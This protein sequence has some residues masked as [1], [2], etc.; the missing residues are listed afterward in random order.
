M[1]FT[2]TFHPV[3]RVATGLA[4][5]A[6]AAVGVRLVVTVRDM[7]QLSQERRQQS[8]TD[9]LTGLHNRRYLFHVLDTFFE[10]C[11]ATGAERSA[12]FLFVDLNRFKEINDTF[13]HP[14]GDELLRQ[15][16]TRLTGALRDTD[17]LVR[18]GG[19]EFAVVL[20][21]GDASYAVDVAQRLTDSLEEPFA[22]DVVSA[23]I[24]ASIGI[25][26]AP[27]DAQ[28]SAGLVWCADVA[29]YR[30]KLGGTAFAS[31]TQDLDE[32]GDQM[33]LVEDLR[34]A[35]NGG[36]LTLHYQPQLNLTTGEILNVEA[37]VRW[38][39]PKLGLLPPDRFIPLAEESGLIAPLTTWVID[40][41]VEQV[42]I[43]RD[44]ARP[45]TVSV[46]I[47][48]S[49]LL[50]PG[51]VDQVR[52]ALS[53]RNLGTDALVLEI[54]ETC[55]ISDFERAR[56]VIGELQDHGF[57]VSIDDFGAGV[58]SLAY[59]GNLAVR[60]LKLDRVFILGTEGG[61]DIRQVD[62]I[63][64]T[65][66]L[67]HAMGLRIV[68]EGIEDHET[69]RLLADLGCDYAQGYWIS[70]P[71]PADDLAFQPVQRIAAR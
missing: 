47:S 62:L 37:L 10:D 12:A 55:V 56:A 64:S 39:H 50:R 36:G 69:L 19:D 8:V 40:E 15:L 43:W 46:N 21:D 9:D 53:A 5:A 48:P 30:S 6:L 35:I 25:A 17:L 31:Y 29:M 27:D 20:I 67:G 60:E 54:T 18:I 63:R 22:L 71:K 52:G 11:A 33:H 14:A 42:A 16:G 49:T 34:A 66:D 7:R 59:L 70:R 26:I 1:L 41:A 28:D 51:F 61:D 3:G 57:C 44:T 58:T 2:A 45:M 24:G 23:H 32:D 13:G 68:A 65:I 4:A 38:N